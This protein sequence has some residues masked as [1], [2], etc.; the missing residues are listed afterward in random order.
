MY[1][2]LYV[3]IYNS[4]HLNISVLNWKLLSTKRLNKEKNKLSTLIKLEGEERQ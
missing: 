1:A 4:V 2:L 3:V